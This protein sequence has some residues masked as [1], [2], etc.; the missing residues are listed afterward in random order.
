MRTISVPYP[1]VRVTKH[2]EAERDQLR[3]RIAELER[4]PIRWRPIA[5]A[6]KTA[7]VKDLESIQSKPLH[8]PCIPILWKPLQISDCCTIIDPT[9][10]AEI[11]GPG[12]EVIEVEE[13]EA[14]RE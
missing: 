3:A 11:V 2:V 9:H 4:Q 13:R 10:F 6:P 5:E 1:F 8:P 7:M 14:S 12:G